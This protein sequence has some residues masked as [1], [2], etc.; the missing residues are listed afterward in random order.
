MYTSD[1]ISPVLPIKHL[2]NQDGEPNMS[3][4]LA[5]GTKPLVSNL[6]VLVC[7]CVVW[8][9]TEHIDG[10]ALNM[11]HQSQKG[12]CGIFIGIIQQWNWY[13]IYVPSTSKVVS[14]PDVVFEKKFLVQQYTH[15]IR[16]YRYLQCN[17]QSSL[18]RTLHH[19]MKKLAIYN[20]FTVWRGR[21]SRKW[22]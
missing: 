3:Q 2:A 4:K 6:R 9:S 22:T 7:P 14:S 10:K 13:L 1:H 15:H 17:H 18:F 20:F 5:T 21:F 11:R 19:L 16:I 12:F 8:K